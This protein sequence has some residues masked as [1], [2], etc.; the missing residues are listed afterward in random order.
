MSSNTLKIDINWCLFWKTIL[1]SLGIIICSGLVGT[2]ALII[3]F[4]IPTN[5][6]IEIHARESAMTISREGFYPKL[7]RSPAS[8]VDTWTDSLMLMQAS[9]NGKESAIERAM[10]IYHYQNPNTGKTITK[11]GKQYLESD[12]VFSFL[13]WGE[14]GST[15]MQRE[16]YARY[17]HGYLVLLRPLLLLF[18]YSQ[19]RMLNLVIITVLVGLTVFLMSKR[20]QQLLAVAYTGTILSMAPWAIGWSLTFMTVFV[21]TSLTVLGLLIRKHG[22]RNEQIAFAFVGIGTAVSYFDYLTYPLVSFAIPLTV[23]LVLHRPSSFRGA[24]C[25]TVLAGIAWA[26]GYA[27]M[28]VS[29]WCISSVLLHRNMFIEATNQLSLRTSS[30]VEGHSI[31]YLQV[32][33]RNFFTFARTFGTVF[34]LLF[35]LTL[36]AVTLFQLVRRSGQYS[37]TKAS[38]QFVRYLRDNSEMIIFPLIALLPFV[39]FVATQNHS[40]IHYWFTNREFAVTAFS[41]TVFLIIVAQDALRQIHQVRTA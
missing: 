26:C 41:G 25:P 37:Q 40:Y 24:V 23:L 22:L 15:G 4:A 28:W 16:A 14:H 29:K 39:W 11:D 18:N 12:P 31:T 21:I 17:W 8:Q 33:R 1:I 3:V 38:E 13:S 10:N 34:L 35:C 32:L 6:A 7:T 36:V 27:L 19:L 5:N 9:Y 30:E 20:R 2:L